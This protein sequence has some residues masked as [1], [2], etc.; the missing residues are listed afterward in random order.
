[1][2]SIVLPADLSCSAITVL[3]SALAD[4]ASNTTKR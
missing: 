4:I 3:L 2:A 1:M